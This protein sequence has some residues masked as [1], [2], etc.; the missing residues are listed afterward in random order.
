MFCL[1]RF[2]LNPHSSGLDLFVVKSLPHGLTLLLCRYF[3]NW[4]RFLVRV[5]FGRPL[6]KNVLAISVPDQGVRVI[7]ARLYIE[8]AVTRR[9]CSWLGSPARDPVCWDFP[10]SSDEVIPTVWSCVNSAH[11]LLWVNKDIQHK[12]LTV[13]TSLA[14]GVG[15]MFRLWTVIHVALN[16]TC[17]TVPRIV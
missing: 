2:V 9:I 7:R 14:F 3:G 10:P 1:L 15:A 17:T 11:V 12:T 13:F 16:V 6:R 5:L 8:Q 4:S